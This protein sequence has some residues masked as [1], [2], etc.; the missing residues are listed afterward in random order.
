VYLHRPLYTLGDA[1]P[2]VGLR[3]LLAAAVPGQW[4]PLVLQGHMQRYERFEVGNITYITTARR[5]AP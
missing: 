3:D 2:E 5:P 1:N 4:R